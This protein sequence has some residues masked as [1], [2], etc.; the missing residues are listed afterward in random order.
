MA[1]YHSPTVV[2]PF[3]PEAEMTALER[4]VLSLVFDDE[5]AGD[6][7]LY[8]HSWCGPSDVI[9]IDA[10][11]LRAA[12]AASQ[13]VDSAIGD[14]AASMLEQYDRADDHGPD[15]CFDIDL[16]EVGHGWPTILADIVRRSTTL[17]EIVVTAAWT[18]TKM[19]S[20]GFGGSI[21]R[22]TATGIQHCSTSDMLEALREQPIS[23]SGTDVDGHETRRRIEAIASS[24]SWDSFTLLLLVSRWLDANGHTE[25]LIEHLDRLVDAEAN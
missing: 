14:H 13:G 22:I 3:I 10:D 24:A 4:R 1:D 7:Q 21:M 23:P 25:K 19:R 6:G 8:F 12:H 16:G 20:D 11:D 17:D 5:P 15:D 18:C 9:S 2:T